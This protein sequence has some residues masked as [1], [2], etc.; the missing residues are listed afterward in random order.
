[1]M[2]TY[3]P[4]GRL[5]LPDGLH[6]NNNNCHC[7]CF[8]VEQYQHNNHLPSCSLP[9][10]INAEQKHHYYCR[11]GGGTFAPPAMSSVGRKRRGAAKHYIGQT[12]I[13]QRVPL[14]CSIGTQTDKSDENFF[15]AEDEAEL[16]ELCAELANRLLTIADKWAAAKLETDQQQQQ[17]QPQK[18]K[19][20]SFLNWICP[21]Q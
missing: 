4:G 3:W 10:G 6:N 14:K 20:A 11:L 13:I 16:V 17:Q 12:P 9:Q 19:W 18:S 8:G 21:P 2:F 7:H 15:L 1:M 5:S